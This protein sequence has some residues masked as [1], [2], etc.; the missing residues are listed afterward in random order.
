MKL[1]INETTKADIGL[2][3]KYKIPYGMDNLSS[4]IGSMANKKT[5]SN[6]LPLEP[7]IVFISLSENIR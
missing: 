2:N 7:R 1:P 5:I 4:V 6:S 3:P